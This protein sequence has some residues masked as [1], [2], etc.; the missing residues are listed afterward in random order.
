MKRVIVALLEGS[1][2]QRGNSNSVN[3]NNNNEREIIIN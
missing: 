1:L 3:N 2:R